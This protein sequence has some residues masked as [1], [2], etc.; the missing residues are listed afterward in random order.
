MGALIA[1]CTKEKVDSILQSQLDQGASMLEI[2]KTH[3]MD[4]PGVSC[5]VELGHKD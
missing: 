1:G 3:P 2:L 5:A 4:L